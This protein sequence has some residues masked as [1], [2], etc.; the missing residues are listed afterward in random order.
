MDEGKLDEPAQENWNEIKKSYYD[1]EHDVPSEK[2]EAF[3]N[4][5]DL[6]NDFRKGRFEDYKHYISTGEI[7]HIENFP[8]GMG[9]PNWL[10]R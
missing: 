5:N 6:M 2:L 4:E 7:I 3:L 1:K 8:V 10:D 9:I